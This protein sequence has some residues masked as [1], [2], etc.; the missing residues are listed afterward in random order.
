MSRALHTTRWTTSEITR[1]RMVY[2]VMTKAELV[3]AFPTHPIGSINSTANALGLR[4][5]FGNRKWQKIAARWVPTFR[6]DPPAAATS[7]DR[8]PLP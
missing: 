7:H 1:L 3:A 6:F 4:K 2:P 8:S 5:V